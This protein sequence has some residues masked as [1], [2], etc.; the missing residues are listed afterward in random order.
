M[1]LSQPQHL[2]NNDGI[3]IV[4]IPY[5]MA[6]KMFYALVPAPGAVRLRKTESQITVKNIHLRYED[7]L[8]LG[9]VDAGGNGVPRPL[10][11]GITLR[12]LVVQTVD[13]NWV[14]TYV[15]GESGAGKSGERCDLCFE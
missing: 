8:S 14:P 6:T 5:A 10:S 3:T 13:E 1:R 7:E 2:G 11:A 15:R 12:K 4:T 9:G